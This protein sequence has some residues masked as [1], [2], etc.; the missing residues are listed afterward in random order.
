MERPVKE[1]LIGAAVLMAAAIILIPEM[2]SGPSRDS[3]EQQAR[4][5][6]SGEGAGESSIKTYTIDLSQ[7]SG[8]Q[9][10]KATPIESLADNRAPPPEAVPPV[11]TPEPAEQ[12]PAQAF[13][14]SQPTTPSVMAATPKPEPRAE[15]PS[16]AATQSE[17]AETP[18]PAKPPTQVQPEPKKPEPRAVASAQTA[19][20]SQVPAGK[21]WVVQLGSYSSQATAQRL[22]NEWRAKGQSAFVMPVSTGGKTLYRVRIGPSKDRAGAEAALKVVKASVPNAA[23]VTHP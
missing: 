10:P 23:V 13:P 7:A 6:A 18:P 20:T 22:A 1:R 16:Q 17:R 12:P 5:A 15:T 3:D 14:E 2:L 21:G 4:T 11:E 9:P 8:T 19:P